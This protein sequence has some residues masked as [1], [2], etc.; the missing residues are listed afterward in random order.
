MISQMGVDDCF[1]IKEINTGTELYRARS[2]SFVRIH[3]QPS[4]DNPLPFSSLQ[5]LYLPVGKLSKV[6]V[7]FEYDEESSR[8]HYIILILAHMRR[9]LEENDFVRT[10]HG[11]GLRQFNQL[12]DL[13][14]LFPY[15]KMVYKLY[16][17]TF[18]LKLTFITLR[19]IFLY[20]LL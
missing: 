12:L 16:N 9:S 19:F 11:P 17:S 15:F 3:Y 1:G 6:S 18:S 20:P 8:A 10:Y 14:S 4:A 5:M 13:C 7:E 2:L